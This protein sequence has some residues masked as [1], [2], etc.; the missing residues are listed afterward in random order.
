MNNPVGDSHASGRLLYERVDG[1]ELK[2]QGWGVDQHRRKRT[3]IDNKQQAT[4]A[5]ILLAI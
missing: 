5:S 4:P 1:K 3:Y 2:K